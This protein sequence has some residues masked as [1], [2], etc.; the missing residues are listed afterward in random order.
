M[1]TAQKAV[2]DGLVW[3]SLLAV[4]I[5]HSTALQIM[6]TVSLFKAAKNVDVWLLPIF[7]C[8]CHLAWSEIAEKLDWAI[9]FITKTL[10]SHSKENPKKT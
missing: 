1:A 7:E 8:I 3:A 2:V 10:K 5:R 9:C 6:P 4:I